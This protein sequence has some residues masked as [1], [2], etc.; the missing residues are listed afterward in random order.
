MAFI[1]DILRVAR[2]DDN[3][4]IDVAILHHYEMYLMIMNCYLPLTRKNF[5]ILLA[6]YPVI[7]STNSVCSNTKQKTKIFYKCHPIF[8]SLY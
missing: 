3:F 8:I 1:R 4:L 2:R 7:G 6:F 5:G